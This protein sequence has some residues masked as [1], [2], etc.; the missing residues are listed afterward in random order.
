[1]K[2][3][4]KSGRNQSQLFRAI[5]F[6]ESRLLL[7]ATRY[8]D[9]NS[10][11][12][13][14]DGTSWDAAYVDLQQALA[15][16]MA[17][18][19]IHVAD[20]TYKPTA[21]TDQTISFVLKTGVSVLGGY[22]GS[23]ASDPNL[24]DIA[25]NV[26]VL[27][28][29][30]GTAGTSTDNSYHVVVGSDTTATAVLDGFTITDASSGG[31][32]NSSSSPTLIN[33]TF[34][35]NS[36]DYPGGG[37]LNVSSSPTLINCTFSGNSA[38][39]GGGMYNSSSSPAL[40]NCIFSGNR[41]S[42]NGGGMFSFSSSP[43]LT[44][45]TFSGNGAPHGGGMYN[46][47]CSVVLTNCTF[48][49]NS[50]PAYAG[51]MYNSG[52]SA[53]LTN[54]T[55]SGNWGAGSAG[56]MYNGDGSAVLTNCTFSGNSSAYYGGGMYNS[57]GSAVLTNCTFSGNLAYNSHWNNGW[58]G[59]IYNDSSSPTLTNC[60]LW[61][62]TAP[63]G[64]Q[65]SGGT[66]AIT[67]SGIQGGFTGTGN[68]NFDPLFVRNPNPGA[69]TVWGTTDDD[70]GD[71]RPQASSPCIDAAS[72]AAVPAGI[73]TDL[74]GNSRFADI[75]GVR[76]PGVVVDMGAYEL[77]VTSLLA[78]G[79]SF[80]FAASKPSVSFTF[81]ANLANSSLLAGD[82]VLQNLTT[83]HFIDC[84][85]ASTAS[86]DP[87]SASA[88]WAFASALPDGNYRATLPAGSVSDAGGNPTSTSYSFDFFALAGDANHDRIVDISDLGI[89]A[90]NWQETGR[91]FAQGDF[92]YDDIVDISDLGILATNWQKS[93]AAPAAPSSSA[94]RVTISPIAAATTPTR[95][96]TRMSLA[97]EVIG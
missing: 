81:N 77:P 82:L 67:Y 68:V 48:S 42:N 96:P 14:H 20:G 3:A 62:N 88:T 12:P 41:V 86:S 4:H 5:E 74:A 93:I 95:R 13:A 59:G 49:G 83:G 64:A 46:I 37:M 87:A 50:G 60:I 8:V 66:P 80:L 25:A 75:A 21:D 30:I 94:I 28:G 6:L 79:G 58:G 19:E 55:F 85:T 78:A 24:R 45:C 29:D 52:G 97:S 91:T 69:D 76:D 33:C 92:N 61:G 32:Y 63:T 34:S 56:G 90:T 72:N 51:G 65:I 35:G 89:L 22:A 53:V 23:G 43:T 27:S 1:M 36:S 47:S 71:L 40:T 7:S 18:D 11:G 70:Y 26:T 16:A 73:A 54:C 38:D 84:G 15:A 44:N 17:G 31:V 2:R 10:A 9:L 57:G 39:S